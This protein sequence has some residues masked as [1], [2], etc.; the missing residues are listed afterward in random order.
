MGV[1]TE[2]QNQNAR[3]AHIKLATYAFLRKNNFKNLIKFTCMS[4]V[5]NIFN[6]FCITAFMNPRGQ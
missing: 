6:K 3:V 2:N 5:P 4:Y 1:S